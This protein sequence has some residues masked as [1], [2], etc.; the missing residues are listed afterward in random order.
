MSVTTVEN[1]IDWIDN[2]ITHNPTLE[3]MADNAV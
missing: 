2:N 1:M 3:E